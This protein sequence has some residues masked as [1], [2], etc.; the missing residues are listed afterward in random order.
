MSAQER[1]EPERR[2]N[3]REHFERVDGADIDVR[4][5]QVAGEIDVLA[6]DCEQTRVCDV[7][8]GEVVIDTLAPAWLDLV[9]V[10]LGLDGVRQVDAT[11]GAP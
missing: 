3:R 1:S 11:E 7:E 8:G 9:A 6:I 2:P 5:Y 4:V 10:Q